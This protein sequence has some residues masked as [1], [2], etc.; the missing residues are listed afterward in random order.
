MQTDILRRAL[1]RW[2]AVLIVPVVLVAAVCTGMPAFAETDDTSAVVSPTETPVVPDPYE[3]LPEGESG[4]F[5][6]VAAVPANVYIPEFYQQVVN[7]SG[8]YIFTLPDGTVHKRLYG[9]LNDK[10]GWYEPVGQDNIVYEGSLP[11]SVADDAALYYS[12]VDQAELNAMDRQEYAG[13]LPPEENTVQVE[14]LNGVPIGDIT[15]YCVAGVVALCILI[16]LC[17]AVSRGSNR[18]KPAR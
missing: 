4:D 12:A 11:I 16:I 2:L 10:Y 14:Q 17:A 8:M 6:R 7:V 3:P 13:I 18:R 15:F 1:L 9:A 5:V